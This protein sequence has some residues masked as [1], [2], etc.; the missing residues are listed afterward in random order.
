MKLSRKHGPAI[1]AYKA[2]DPDRWQRDAEALVKATERG[3]VKWFLLRRLNHYAFGLW[4]ALTKLV[5]IGVAVAP[6]G[7]C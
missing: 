4:I 6:V 1:H 2:A 3:R 7:R 5:L